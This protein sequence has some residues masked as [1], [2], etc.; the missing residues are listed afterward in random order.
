MKNP[1]IY[2]S[3]EKLPLYNNYKVDARFKPKVDDLDILVS[4]SV[5][6]TLILNTVQS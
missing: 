1:N 5:A 2:S 4:S 3:S 6:E